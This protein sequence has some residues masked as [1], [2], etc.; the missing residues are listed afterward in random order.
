MGETFQVENSVKSLGFIFDDKL[1]MNKQI[2]HICSVGYGMLRNLW[3]ISKKVT[4]KTLRTQLIHSSI[5]SRIN[6]CN[7]LYTSLPKF[8]TKKIQKLINASTRFIFNITGT[9][10]F[11]HITPFLKQVH[12][13]PIEFR[14]EFKICLIIYKC[15][16]GN[17]PTYLTELIKN[18][19][20]GTHRT[21]RI[22]LDRSLLAF[23]S[24]EKQT[25]KSR[26]FSHAAPTIWNRLPKYIRDSKNISLFKSNLK[27]YY[28]KKWDS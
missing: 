3:K 17:S 15:L 27:T 12:F 13:L 8:Q 23:S 6:Y 14:I 19:K 25:Y 9:N 7:S 26:G 18:K 28:Y 20:P 5:L 4:D 11:Q 21:L 2:N 10:R 22:D 1:D 16:Y 24:T